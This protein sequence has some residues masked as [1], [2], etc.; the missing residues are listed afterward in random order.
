MFKI[1]ETSTDKLL[2]AEKISQSIINSKLS[3]CVQIIDGIKSY[4]IWKNKIVSSN[5]Y[6]IKI[7]TVENHINKISLIIKE[8]SN[9]DVPEVIS[10]DFRI[11]D[12]EYENWFNE[13]I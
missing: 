8:K 12:K 11:E 9:Y 1:I 2:I 7:K 3:P 6:T 4:Y 5:E 10:Y 13:N